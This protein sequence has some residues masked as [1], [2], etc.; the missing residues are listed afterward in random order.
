MRY[1]LKTK[2]ENTVI[3][4]NEA[5]HKLIGYLVGE[6]GTPHLEAPG[7]AYTTLAIADSGQTVTFKKE[8][9]TFTLIA[10]HTQLPIP[11]NA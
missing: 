1:I 5:A 6:V 7:L 4:E 11:S 10:Y 3:T 2:N 8:D 9:D